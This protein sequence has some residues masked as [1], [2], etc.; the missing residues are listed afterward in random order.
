MRAATIRAENS[1]AAAARVSPLVRRAL[2]PNPGPFT[3][4]GT[5]SYIV[6]SGDVAII[7]PGPDDP[8]HVEALLATISNEK[9]RYVLVTHTHRDHSPGAHAL[10]EAT[11][12]MITGCRPYAP[13]ES[14]RVGGFN[15]DAAHDLAYAPD[16]VLKDGDELE[17]GDTSLVALETPGHTANHVCFAL[18][19][20]QALFTGDHV[21]AWATTVIAP[22]DG[23]MRDYMASVERLRARR[24]SIYW[25]GHGEPIRDP[26]RYL[27]ALIHHRRAR[28]AAIL[29]RLEAGDE[30]IAEIVAHI[31][32]GVDKRLH[33]A[34][35]M[36]T[37]A[38]LEDLIS[39]G[40][41]DCAGTPGLQS[42]FGGR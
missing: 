1:Q 36:T 22:P 16:I 35:A 28:E 29:Q 39:R 21:M 4:T 31:Y 5:C 8:R 42:R 2:A 27:R 34:A 32:E 25:P 17:I 26:Q 9:L 15:L 30:T 38:H 13:S 33:P 6:G 41:V 10:K 23:S 11:G 40:L 20:E 24:D 7:D 12:A 18:A 37:L 19:E 14:N 3:Y